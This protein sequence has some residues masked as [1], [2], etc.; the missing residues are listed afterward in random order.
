M[1]EPA[2]DGRDYFLHSSLQDADRL[3]HL[4]QGTNTC[5]IHI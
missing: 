1:E 3:D 4:N 2:A 5:K